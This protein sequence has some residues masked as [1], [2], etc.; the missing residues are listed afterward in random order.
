MLMVPYRQ[1]RLLQLPRLIYANFAQW[2]KYFTAGEWSWPYVTTRTLLGAGGG[3]GSVGAG[4]AFARQL[5]SGSRQAG[6]NKC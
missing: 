1:T 5:S 4:S 6:P 3:H 2:I